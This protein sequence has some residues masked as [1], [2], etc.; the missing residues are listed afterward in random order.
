[1]NGGQSWAGIILDTF[2]GLL[3][4]VGMA[5]H[6]YLF[7][8]AGYFVDSVL[9]GPRFRWGSITWHEH[10]GLAVSLLAGPVTVSV[11]GT[12]RFLG[13]TIGGRKVAG[14]KAG[15]ILVQH[16]FRYECVAAGVAML[17]AAFMIIL[18]IATLEI[19]ITRG[20][21]YLVFLLA[22]GIILLRCSRACAGCAAKLMWEVRCIGFEHERH[23][24]PVESIPPRYPQASDT[25]PS[26]PG[27]GMARA[28][29]PGDRG[30]R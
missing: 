5:L 12:M 3:W 20:G 28:P 6:T 13:G 24:L 10:L 27:P 18:A 14:D 17:V 25:R 7:Y 22:A 26:G 2:G 30:A 16:L 4:L 23:S 9:E 1:M 15:A 29:C 19:S 21:P 8:M 11:G